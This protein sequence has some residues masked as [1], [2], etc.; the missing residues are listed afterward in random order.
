MSLAAAFGP[1][2]QP[3]IVIAKTNDLQQVILLHAGAPTVV[4]FY[5]RKGEPISLRHGLPC[6]IPAM[7]EPG[8]LSLDQ[9]CYGITNIKVLQI[10]SP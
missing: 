9:L 4:S 10:P 7:I 6:T 5:V 8:N 1:N 3:Q 2:A